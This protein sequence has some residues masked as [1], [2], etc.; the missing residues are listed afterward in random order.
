[1]DS[2]YNNKTIRLEQSLK[3]LGKVCIA[4]SGGV[5]SSF[6]LASALANLPRENVL[7]VT[8]R[9][10]LLSLKDQ[11]RAQRGLDF[12]QQRFGLR[13]RILD[14]DPLE[15][16]EINTNV[17]RRCYFCKDKLYTLFHKI[18]AEE[19]FPYL[20]DGTNADDLLEDRPGL[21][22]LQQH[23]I[24]IPLADAGLSKKEIRL[25]SKQ[26]GLETWDLPSSSCLA[27]RIPTDAPI[28]KLLLQEIALQE[29]QIAA[30]GF[31]GCRVRYGSPTGRDGADGMT[32]Q[33]EFDASQYD[34]QLHLQKEQEIRCVF[35]G[36]ERMRIVFARAK[37][38]R[39]V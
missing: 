2:F 21:L 16:P 35:T 28:D 27:T 31:P 39:L 6:L 12:F 8:A 20:L 24:R 10:V 13:Y 3:Q 29:E 25:F 34:E 11:E 32:I 37:K 19:G 5:D 14:W 17:K 7:A 15:L 22:A 30:L 26:L 36:L 18:I 33:V 23:G 9:S 1:M 38:S 4:S